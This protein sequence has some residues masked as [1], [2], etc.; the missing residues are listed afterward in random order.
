MTTPREKVLFRAE[1][2]AKWKAYHLVKV[3]LGLIGSIVGLVVVP[4][5][6]LGVGQWYCRRYFE[7]LEC[8]LCDRSLVIGR[9][10]Y[11]RVEKTIPLDKIQ[12]L[13][14]VEGPLLKA[15]GLC[16]LKVETAGQS[17]QS[18]GSE[19][20]LIGIVEA[21]SLRDRVLDQRDAV[22]GIGGAAAS[23]P[24]PKPETGGDP[25]LL[26]AIRDSLQRIEALVAQGLERRE[27]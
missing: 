19:V 17:S 24:R 2:D 16:R 27:R 25:N 6:I 1:F 8:L 22:T 4:F 3:L 20:D 14:L 11:V 26:A 21:R 18:G 10:L 9:G 15:F 12:D 13:T 5:W 7:R 23:D